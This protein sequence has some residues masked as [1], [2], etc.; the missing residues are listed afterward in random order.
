PAMLT[1]ANLTFRVTQDAAQGPTSGLGFFPVKPC[2][3]ADTRSNS[4]LTG[5]FGAPRMAGGS[6]RDFPIP[7]G[8]CGI[9]ANAKA[10]SVNVTVVPPG[11]LAYL[12]IWPAG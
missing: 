1:I 4:G 6:K 2:R 12:S 10:Y 3:V 9:P 5:A 11:F 7:S 8:G